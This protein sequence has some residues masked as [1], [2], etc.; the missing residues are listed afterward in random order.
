MIYQRNGDEKMNTIINTLKKI[1]NFIL[2]AFKEIELSEALKKSMGIENGYSVETLKKFYNNAK[3]L[4]DFYMQDPDNIKVCV[5]NGN[6]K[7]GRVMNVSLLPIFTCLTR[8]EGCRFFCYDIKACMQYKN[9]LLARVRNTVLLWCNRKAY[10]EQIEQK[11]ARRRKNK[12]F[13]WHVA[14]DIIDQD[15]FENMV[16]IAKNHSD[17]VFWTYTK[18]YHIIN[19]YCDKY[20][21]ESIPSN[22]SIMF[23]QWDGIKMINPYN[24]PEFRVYDDITNVKEHICPGNCE[25][26]LKAKTGCPYGVTSAVKKH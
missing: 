11:I 18:Q 9:V 26:C 1:A 14:G 12:Y 19:R 4:I 2:K 24:F 5:T 16:R 13:R 10:F 25:L 8:C 15:Y 23:S 17:F 20:G 6:R 21:K 3:A 7:I 22:L